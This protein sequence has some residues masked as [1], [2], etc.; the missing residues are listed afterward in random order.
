MTILYGIKN[1]DTVKKARQWLEARHLP[2][3]FHDFR[4]DGLEQ[5]TVER[6]LDILSTEK[7]INKRSTTWKRLTDEERAALS[8]DKTTAAHVVLTHPTLIKRPLLETDAQLHCGFKDGE[9]A[10]IF[11]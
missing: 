11:S 8:S 2:Y 6:W 5:Q 1:C 10:A 7:L 9:Y 4:T 3:Q